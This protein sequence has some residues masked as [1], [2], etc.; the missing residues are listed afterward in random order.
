MSLWTMA[1]MGQGD[2]D[3]VLAIERS[4]FAT[5]WNRFSYENELT[6]R[7]AYSYIV[8]SGTE[9]NN[10]YIFAYTCFHLVADEM[11]LLKIAVHENWQ[12]KGIASWLLKKSLDIAVKRGVERAFLEVRPTNINAIGLYKKAGF[13]QVGIQKG[14]YA[15]T[16]ED[17]LVMRIKLTIG[18]RA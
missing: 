18:G 2:L 13:Y 3:Q 6:S 9:N 7:H 1:P 4:L 16:Q 10:P 15:E 14:Y 5:P 11:H 8:K 12:Q 17:A